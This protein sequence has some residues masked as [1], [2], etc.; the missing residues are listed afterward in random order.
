MQRY[1][2]RMPDAPAAASFDVKVRTLQCPGC[3]APV[4]SSL[5]G[6]VTTC[7]Y[8]GAKVEVAVRARSTRAHV[9]SSVASEMARMASLKAQAEHP[10][11]G[12]PYD[13]EHTPASVPVVGATGE[14]IG[15]A[16]QAASSVAVTTPEA[17]HEVCW[18]AIRFA[19]GLLAARRPLEARAALETALD[20]LLDEGHQHLIR[21]QLAVAAAFEGDLDS[22]KGWL[23]ECDAAPEVL[24][25]D[26][27]YRQATATVRLARSDAAGVL[28]ILGEREGQ[29]PFLDSQAS[30]VI[31]IPLRLQALEMLGRDDVVDRA[32]LDLVTSPAWTIRPAYARAIINQIEAIQYVPRARQ[33]P[34]FAKARSRSHPER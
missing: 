25:L 10:S 5:E 23:E 3:G 22:A 15:K 33:R 11:R 31:R 8:C 16:W 17:G 9:V 24:E 21:C 6:G 2:P 27:P 26:T 29:F 7:T 32:L 30:A 13:L 19:Q 34:A 4:A 20:R 18:L 1:S 12:N 28:A 14:Q